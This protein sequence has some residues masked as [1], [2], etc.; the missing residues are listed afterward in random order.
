MNS[1]PID[2]NWQIYLEL[3]Q[4]LKKTLLQ[5]KKIIQDHYLY[6]GIKQNRKYRFSDV[7][8]DVNLIQYRKNNHALKRLTEIQLMIYWIK[9]NTSSN[10]P[11]QITEIIENNM[12]GY[13]HTK[14]YQLAK[15]I[16]ATTNQIYVL[17]EIFYN[18]LENITLTETK[19][20]ILLTIANSIYP[21]FG[22]G[23]NWLLD[24]NQLVEKEY[25]CIGLCFC[26][27]FNKINFSTVNYLKYKNTHIIQMPFCIRDIIQLIIEI[28]PECIS[29]QGHNRLLFCKIANLLRVPFMTGFAFWND[30]IEIT[31]DYSNINM[32]QNTF[33]PH[34]NLDIFR[35]Y[36]NTYLVSDFMKE[37]V[38][39]KLKQFQ[40]DIIPSISH[41]SHY[42]PDTSSTNMNERKYICI[43]NSHFLK[44]GQELLYLLE[45]LNPAFAILAVITEKDHYEKNIIDAF[46]KRNS[47]N[48]INI[49]HTSKI[50]NVKHIY[51][52]CRI[53][54]IPSIVD[55]TFC[56]VAYEGM[57]LGLPIISYQSGNL[58]YLL[59]DY[60]NNTFIEA[61]IL[62]K[63]LK[64]TSF[65]VS[66]VILDKWLQ[67]VNERYM[68]C[69][70]TGVNNYKIVEELIKIKLLSTIK[71]PVKLKKRD[72][73]GF[74]CPFV[75]QGLGIQCREYITF[76]E[77]NNVK[78]AVFSFKPYCAVQVDKNEWK[79]D[80]VY[81]SS[82]IR[83]NVTVE[84]IIDFVFSYDITTIIIPEICYQ[85]IYKT[86]DCFKSIGVKVVAIIN[87]E[88][89]RYTE[90][91]YYHYFD[92]ILTNNNS[93]YKLLK[94]I[95]PDHNVQL[96]E[97]NNY[98]L[99]RNMMIRN[100]DINDITQTIKIA[101]FGGINS[102]IRK[103]ID[104]TYKA[105]G[106]LEKEPAFHTYYNYH[107]TIYIQGEDVASKPNCS[108]INTNNITISVKNYSYSELMA[109]VRV[110]DI[111]IHMGDHEGLGLGFFEALNQN[112]ALIT[113]DTYPNK[114]YVT[115]GVNGYIINCGFDELKDNNEAIVK[116]GVINMSHYVFT[117]C[118]ILHHKNRSVLNDIIQR[119]K[120]IQNNY[121]TNF[122]KHLKDINIV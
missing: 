112:K 116:K 89:L 121:E 48:N 77:K 107:L 76:L 18:I 60:V 25:T 80:R 7:Y 6:S 102:Y 83:E 9:E 11:N 35:S 120:L 24:I 37:F 117:L 86:I 81:Y 93:S 66:K 97:F 15:T 73:I 58:E 111:I 44:G 98:Y 20:P 122:M 95:L 114:E 42:H 43:L 67:E 63:T 53:L 21:A 105:F 46:R 72:T 54:L 26:D 75:D 88:I 91:F 82:N 47:V 64:S 2:F 70:V 101:T 13:V 92:L 115:D 29:H 5:R 39:R 41:H 19:K 32:L 103:N 87:I 84:E 30:L 27:V 51:N 4:D 78:T 100:F 69:E 118:K 17:P 109:A 12:G 23:E 31:K 14:N 119:N 50:E 68:N 62:D 45:N 33:A 55:E 113:M 10:A 90:M 22:G 38:S 16:A 71:M 110:Q 104:K 94:Q 1:L 28:K 56:R 65:I 52:K 57:Q 8:P 36:S 49:L 79:H 85:A 106:F 96:L 99:P 3:N 74:F 34:S 40:W 108:L 61:P 59:K